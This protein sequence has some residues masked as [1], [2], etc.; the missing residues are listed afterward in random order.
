M[1][2][3][4]QTRILNDSG[5][6]SAKYSARF[7]ATAGDIVNR[8]GQPTTTLTRSVINN[9]SLQNPSTDDDVALEV[10]A[11]GDSVVS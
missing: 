1:L 9:D 3:I 11:F 7:T 6:S 4:V 2:H 8:L 10:V 5:Y